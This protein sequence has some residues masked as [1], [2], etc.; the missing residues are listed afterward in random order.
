MEEGFDKTLEI[1]G[2][3]IKLGGYIDRIDLSSMVLTGDDSNEFKFNGSLVNS[4]NNNNS[5]GGTISLKLSA[6]QTQN[7]GYTD[8][9][10]TYH[11]SVTAGNSY[12]L[13]DGATLTIEAI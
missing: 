1:D 11:D 10:G 8:D 9:A 2:K 12:S 7:I 6:D 13:Q 3:E 4:W 5:T